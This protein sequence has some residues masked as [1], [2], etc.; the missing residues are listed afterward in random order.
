MKLV[1][2]LILSV[3]LLS[4]CVVVPETDT[5]KVNKCEIS[6]DRK[7][8]KVIN[9]FKDTNTFYSISGLVLLPISGVVSG[10]YVAINNVY[11]LGQETFV[12]GSENAST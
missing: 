2:F 12:C 10:T 1:P 3:S 4:A 8:L 5:A 6:S 9:G 11:H 7:T